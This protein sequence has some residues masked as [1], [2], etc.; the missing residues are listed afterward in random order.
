VSS[1]AITNRVVPAGAGRFAVTEECSASL[2]A[3]VDGIPCQPPAA[4]LRVMA[5]CDH[6]VDAEIIAQAIRIVRDAVSDA[7]GPRIGG[8]RFVFVPNEVAP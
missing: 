4:P 1:N 8:G 6:E 2:L 3:A 5:T 7:G